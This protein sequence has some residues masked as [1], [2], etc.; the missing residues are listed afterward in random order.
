MK[1]KLALLLTLILTAVTC[2]SMSVFTAFASNQP[3]IATTDEMI[4]S[5]KLYD[6]LTN[7]GSKLTSFNGVVT[8][9][10]DGHIIY[11]EEVDGVDLTL[12]VTSGN[13]IFLVLRATAESAVW[14]G[15]HGY[16]LMIKGK[17]NGMEVHV[18]KGAQTGT[19]FTTLKTA[20]S[21]ETI[22]DGEKHSV[23]YI[24]EDIDGGVKITFTL[25]GKEIITVTDESEVYGVEGTHF[26]I[27]SGESQSMCK[28]Y[29][30]TGEDVDVSDADYITL[31]S[32][33][34]LEKASNWNL[35][36]ALM[37]VGSS[38]S[39]SLDQS[40]AL[41]ARELKN[42]V[43]A[44]DIEMYDLNGN[45]IAI[46]LNANKA[47]VP[48]ND[49]FRSVVLF[50]RSTGI[51]IEYWNPQQILASVDFASSGINVNERM[52]VEAGIYQVKLSTGDY[53][54]IK[55]AVNGKELYNAP[56]LTSNASLGEGC[57]G[58]VNYGTAK[59]SIFATEDEID[60]LPSA[61]DGTAIQRGEDTDITNSVSVEDFAI[62][63]NSFDPYYSFEGEEMTIA[64]DGYSTYKNSINFE[65]ISFDFKF[66]E[67]DAVGQFA[68]FAFGKKTQY[69]I[70]DAKLAKDYTNYGYMIR[71]APSGNITLVKTDNGANMK[72][73][74]NYDSAND[75]GISFDDLAWHTITIY[76]SLE[77][78]QM[79]ISIFVD[80]KTTGYYACDT[81]Y[82]EPNYPL[83]GF[84]SFGNTTQSSKYFVK[85]IKYSGTETDVASTLKAD[86]VNFVTYFEDEEER[87]V[88]F[89]FD[90]ASYTSK[91][92]EIYASDEN[93][94]EG[95]LLGRVFPKHTIFDLGDYNG[96]YVVVKTV[97]FTEA[98][99][100]RELLKLAENEVKFEDTSLV[101][102]IA[103]K[104]SE[105]GAHFVYKGTNEVFTPVGGNYMGL[106]GGDHS[107]FD[108]ATSFTT[109]DYDPI[110]AEAMISN[111]AKN[112]GNVIRVFLIG[113]TATN[114]GI[115]GDP[116]YDINDENYYYEGLY[117]PYME[118][119]VHFLRTAQKYGVYVMLTLGDADVPSNAYYMNIQGGATL[120]RNYMYFDTRGLTARKTYAKN[121]ISYF[122]EKAP[123]CVSGIFS[124][125]LQNEFA[126]YGDQWPFNLTS[127]TVTTA[128]GKTYDMGDADSRELCYREG[129]TY[130]INQVYSG[131][132]SVDMNVL[133]NEGTFTRNI[134]GNNHVYG[135]QGI[136]SGDIRLPAT[137]DIYLNT[138]IDFL[139]VH[140]YFANVNGNTVLSSFADDLQYMNY[141]SDE[142]QGLLKKKPLFMGEFGPN[143]RIFPTTEDANEV[144]RETVRLATESG[145]KGFAVWTLESHN[146]TECWN[147]LADDGKFDVFRD[148]VRIHR[149]VESTENISANNVT[150][151]VGES[152]ESAINGLIEGDIVTYTVDGENYTA[153]PNFTQKGE[154]TVNY[155]VE[156]TYAETVYGSFKV[157]VIEAE[158][159]STTPVESESKIES[160]SKPNTSKKGCKGSFGGFGLCGLALVA[161]YAL[162]KKRKAN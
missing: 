37:E 150:V 121:V 33:T 141:W 74:M 51:S 145:F 96:N 93:G 92:V 117:V 43:Y 40:K 98:G 36:G 60:E 48:W 31:T 142:V 161:G 8:S 101:K 155:K 81:D 159:E 58:I 162:T 17:A 29:S 97:G 28:I 75:F 87:F 35:N 83:D 157:T 140:I 41:F 90:S 95:D 123:D 71:I 122:T 99:S 20:N 66:E 86:A 52:R 148:L 116:A 5:G 134:V 138:N 152:V 21:T 77:N 76:R 61:T 129:V 63:A 94:T 158:G 119:V 128:N 131:I 1:K 9:S 125:E 126:V 112:N 100:K 137:F 2:I 7:V 103:V 72:R 39:G 34:M 114:P 151:K 67:K 62:I 46:Y 59:Y 110:K 44:F 133:V 132:K 56:I 64:N 42:T 154:Y 54:Y 84:I 14:E 27:C 85:N 160:N 18:I 144:W 102:R 105:D 38:V 73:L 19:N 57:F 118:N 47:D 23:K 22:Y 135:M 104:K 109:A 78:D 130:Y 82:Y 139:D 107:T 79:K 127:G 115:S 106:R 70:V 89:C 120:A 65:K 50:F 146:Q 53:T 6:S 68:E 88:Y 4:A 32:K 69:S 136:T 24:S 80:D 108:A 25:D 124:I 13:S 113:R 16:F 12:K 153:I 147:I 10:G 3:K 49:G 111:L 26:Y 143:A 149:G 11:D 45:W 91:W 30:S 15:G 55:V 156:R